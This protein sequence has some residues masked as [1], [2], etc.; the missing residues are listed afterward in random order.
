MANNSTKR[1]K[2]N[3]VSGP[4]LSQIV[5][6]IRAVVTPQAIILF[7]SYARG[8]VHAGSDLD[9]LVIADVKGPRHER[10]VP[11]YRA[12]C[13]VLIPMDIVVYNRDEVR[14]WSQVPQAFVTTAIREG[15]VLY[16][17]QS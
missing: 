15:K 17:K 2:Q 5:R 3:E 4:M 9:L 12:L 10:A 11:I 7:G 14:E 13:D 8:I 16:E 1:N 6:R